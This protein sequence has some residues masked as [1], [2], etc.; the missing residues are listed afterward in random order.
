[1]PAFQFFRLFHIPPGI[2]RRQERHTFKY[3]KSTH[4]LCLR[5][6]G[7]FTRRLANRLG[8]PPHRCRR[9]L[10]HLQVFTCQF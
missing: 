7:T 1:M 6:R 8:E 10:R 3:G 2:S 5:A 4:S 9:R